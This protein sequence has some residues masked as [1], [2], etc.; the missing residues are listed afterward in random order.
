MNDSAELMSKTE[1]LAMEYVAEYMSR[2]DWR[3]AQLW[4]EVTWKAAAARQTP[5][6]QGPPQ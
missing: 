3:R 5:G 4:A 6:T 2:C 1:Q